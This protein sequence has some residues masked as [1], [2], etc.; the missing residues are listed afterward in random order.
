VVAPLLGGGLVPDHVLHLAVRG[1]WG[2]IAYSGNAAGYR[3]GFT[4]HPQ[5]DPRSPGTHGHY[6]IDYPAGSGLGLHQF[7]E[8]IIQF[9]ATGDLPTCVR[10]ISED[11]HTSHR[12][13]G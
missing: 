2:Y 13:A 11:D 5:G 9:L 8:A 6:N 3:D 7:T 12:A 1:I 10:W 4:G